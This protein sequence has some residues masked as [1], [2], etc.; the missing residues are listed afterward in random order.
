LL[1]TYYQIQLG[2]DELSKKNV[3]DINLRNKKALIVKKGLL[4]ITGG[5]YDHINELFF[6]TLK[7]LN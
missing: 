4:K 7:L 3:K 6:L 1:E 5:P 2:E